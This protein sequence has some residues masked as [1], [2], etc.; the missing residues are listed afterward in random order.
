MVALTW[1]FAACRSTEPSLPTIVGRWNIAGFSDSG[2]AGVTTGAMTFAAGGTWTA[3]GTVTYPGEPL[4]SLE[5]SGTWAQ[6]GL[7]LT[8]TAAGATPGTWDMVF[9][10]DQLVLNGRA[11][12]FTVI[13]LTRAP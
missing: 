10:G 1:A 6:S 13:T 11:P 8:L 9:T 2:T 12:I 3:L 4:D 5:V 7:V